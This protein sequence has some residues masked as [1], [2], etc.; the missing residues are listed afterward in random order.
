MAVQAAGRPVYLCGTRLD[1]LDRVSA[2]DRVLSEGSA[3]RGGILVNPNV[4][5]LVKVSRDP[6]LREMV[7]GADLTL[8]D[9]MPLVWA[10]RLMGTPLPE[11]VPVSEMILTL[12]AAAANHGL[13]VFL[14]GGSPGVAEAAATRFRRQYPG[15]KVGW[16]CPPFGFEQRPEEMAAIEEA[17][18]R[19]RPA[20]VYCGLGFPK[21]E[22][23]MVHLYQRFPAMWFVGSGAAIAFAAGQQ[24]RAPDWMQR[25]G[26]EWLHRLLKEPR[27]LSRRYIVEDIPFALKLLARAAYQR[28]RDG[29]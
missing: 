1:P 12:T 7:N 25:A 29:S 13:G 23:L 16:H 6:E 10:S 9:G 28:G 27:R 5:V 8:A 17:L 15:V 14:L 22:R 20:V 11:R 19:D 21:Q 3:G 26:L 4:D 18:G 24:S 2:I